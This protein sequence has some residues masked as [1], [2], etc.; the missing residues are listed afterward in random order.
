MVRS[1]A[2]F[3][4]VP[5]MQLEFQNYRTRR[6][7]QW[8]RATFGDRAVTWLHAVRFCWLHITSTP[9]EPELGLIN[10]LLQ[11]GEVAVDVGA[12]GANWTIP[13]ARRV[14]QQGHVFAFEAHPYYADVTAKM[15]RLLQAHNVT[16]FGVGL[17]DTQTQAQFLVETADEGQ[18]TCTGRVVQEPSPTGSTLT[19]ELRRLDDLAREYPR[20]YQTRLLKCDVEGFELPVLRGAAG[21]IARARPIVITEIAHSSLHGYRDADLFAFFQ[22]RQYQSFVVARDER[23]LLPSTTAGDLDG[24]QR[25]NR[26][27]IPIEQL[28]RYAD[29]IQP[30]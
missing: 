16:F 4:G 6:I 3:M 12:N 24:A 22:E 8:L 21:I 30:T 1:L 5:A 26:I 27:M 28:A 2:C 15:V 18:L 20:L 13:L 7:K 29:L 25:V 23:H 19:I 9:D 10:Q 14:G 11:P 17:S